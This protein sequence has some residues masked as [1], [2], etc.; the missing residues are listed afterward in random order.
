M[1]LDGEVL[2]N[3]DQAYVFTVTADGGK[4]VLQNAKTGTYLA[5]RGGYLYSYKTNTAVY[6]RWAMAMN[7]TTVD[8]TNASSKASCHLTYS[9]KGYFAMG[10]NA[11]ANVFFWKLAGETQSTVYTTVID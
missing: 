8:A 11:D 7:G 10:R 5:N 6:C 2:N 4:L 3:V 1:T 9:N